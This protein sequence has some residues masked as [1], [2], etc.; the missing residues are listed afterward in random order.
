MKESDQEILENWVLEEFGERWTKQV[1]QA[2]GRT[3]KPNIFVVEEVGRLVGFACF[4]VV[5]AKKGLFGPMGTARYH[6]QKGVGKALL[7]HCLNEMKE[8]GYAYAIIGEAGPIEFYETT[9]EAKVIP[10]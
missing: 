2:F 7:H 6:R 3:P 5:D 9:C 1:E 8:V 10:F 4:D